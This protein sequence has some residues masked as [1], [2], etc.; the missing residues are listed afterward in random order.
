MCLVSDSSVHKDVE[1]F[2]NKPQSPVCR[3]RA[4][5]AF[6]NAPKK[7]VPAIWLWRVVQ[8][9]KETPFTQAMGL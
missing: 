9:L 6:L 5:Q 3:G 4:L 2:L 1:L 8:E 7:S